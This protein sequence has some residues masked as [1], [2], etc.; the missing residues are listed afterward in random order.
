MDDDGTTPITRENVNINIV[1]RG[2]SGTVSAPKRVDVML[3][4]VNI[5][6][7]ED[8]SAI[9]LKTISN[10]VNFVVTVDGTNVEVGEFN[11][12]TKTLNITIKE[13]GR[14]VKEAALKYD[15]ITGQIKYTSKM[16][17]KK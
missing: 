7:S 8:Y 3:R 14:V 15:E 1:Y 12:N 5:I 4:N 11:E 10:P 16:I 9:E 2:T 13:N 6:Q 17:G